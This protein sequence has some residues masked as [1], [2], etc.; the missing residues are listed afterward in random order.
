MESTSDDDRRERLQRFDAEID[1]LTAAVEL[2]RKVIPF[3]QAAVVAAGAVIL[4]ITIGAVGF[5]PIAV[6]GGVIA[7]TMGFLF[8]AWRRRRLTLMATLLQVAKQN[9]A[10]LIDEI[11][12]TPLKK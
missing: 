12:P 11:D 6:I 3:A 9:K 10:A 2:G 7:L 8:L 4:A 5:D 1:R